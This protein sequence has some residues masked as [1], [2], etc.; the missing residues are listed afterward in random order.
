MT[1]KLTRR[2]FALGCSAGIAAMAGGRLGGLVF[3][4][5]KR[6]QQGAKD[7]ILLVVFL[8]GGMDGLHFCAPVDDR[9]Y[10]A[11]RAGDLRIGESG[12]QAG[13]RLDRGLG[14]DFRLHQGARPLHELYQAG[15]LAIVHACGLS[16]GTRSHFDAMDLMERGSAD[17]KGLSTGWLARHLSLEQPAGLLPV[18]A[19]GSSTP[20]SLLG[21]PEAVSIWQPEGFALATHW[22]E[23]AEASEILR[24]FYAGGESPLHGAARRTLDA[25]R[26]VQRGIPRDDD[27]IARPYEP[28]NRAEY[29]DDWSWQQSLITVAQLIK[30]DL[31]LT[32]ATLD[33]GGWDTHEGQG[34]R[35]PQ[36]VDNLARGLGALY[37]DL[38][39]YH[40]RLTIVVMSEFGRRLKSNESG[41]T[42]HG[43]GN[44]MMVMG[45]QVLGGRMYGSWPGLA[46]DQLDDRADLAITT[47]YRQVLAEILVRGLGN[48]RLGRVFPGLERYQ[49]LGLLQGQDLPIDWTGEQPTPVLPTATPVPGGTAT[50]GGGRGGERVYLPWVGRR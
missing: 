28:E 11:A 17:D 20:G 9:D 24:G 48:P 40:D 25:V 29:P 44:L 12:E 50:P 46:N 21:S 32:T 10:V 47:D 39:R 13:L 37:N 7:P 36:Q 38:H 18:V 16:N 3:A 30:M 14:G 19:A 27:G 45:R 26:L 49:P 2:Q 42:D 22:Q 31:G 15:Q 4:D 5:P 41:G 1:V 33:F 34:W 43:H 35:F 6:R 23:P 8:R